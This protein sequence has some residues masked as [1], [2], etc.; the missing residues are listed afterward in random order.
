MRFA[1]VLGIGL[2]TPVF[3]SSS[4]Q[5]LTAR[6]VLYL[7]LDGGLRLISPFMPFISE[8]LFQRLPRKSPNEPPSI[9]VTPYP[10]ATQEYSNFRNETIEKEF[11]VAQKIIAVI[12]S[13]RSD[14]NLGNKMR[15]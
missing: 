1:I 7:C 12:R 13:T 5:V 6:H 11:E 8:E 14:Y 10:L 3:F 15:F 9:C 4:V 2:E